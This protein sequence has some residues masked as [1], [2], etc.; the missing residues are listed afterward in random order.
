LDAERTEE[1]TAP[2]LFPERGRYALPG[3][4][5][6]T[7]FPFGFFHK[8]S[9][10]DVPLEYTV[11]PAPSGAQDWSADVTARF[12]DIQRNKV[13]HGEEYFGLR[14]WRTGEDHRRVHWKTSAKR[15]A[16]VVREQEEQEQR[17][18]ILVLVPHTGRSSEPPGRARHRFELGLSK[19]VGLI[20][21]LS[22]QNFQVGLVTPD[23]QITAGGGDNH[24]DRMMMQL[25]TLEHAQGSPPNLSALVPGGHTVAK[26]GIGFS[27]ALEQCGVEFD[28][29]LELDELDQDRERP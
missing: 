5:L 26:V 23:A 24:S 4:R 3:L 17:A 6:A 22:A 14:D 29:V 15:G 10:V 28:L 19:T 2:Y 9:E 13:G 16:L 7:R 25:A 20:Q 21:E 12:G 8:V 27:A 18:V 11:F 1:V